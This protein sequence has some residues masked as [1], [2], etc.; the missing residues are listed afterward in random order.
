MDNA[1]KMVALLQEIRDNQKRQL[2]F[3]RGAKKSW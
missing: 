2:D 1:E 3:A